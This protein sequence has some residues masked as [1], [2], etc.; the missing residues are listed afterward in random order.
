MPFLGW[1]SDPLKWLSDLQL[2]NEKVTLNHLVL[3]FCWA[4]YCKSSKLKDSLT[5]SQ[6]NMNSV[7]VAINL[8]MFTNNEYNE[9]YLYV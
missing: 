1:L 5:K 8:L 6:F 3:N 7:E 2:G 9:W 4:I